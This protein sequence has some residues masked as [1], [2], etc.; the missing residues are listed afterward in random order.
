MKEIKKINNMFYT[1][2]IEENFPMEMLNI[3]CDAETIIDELHSFAE[4]I[5]EQKDAWETNGLTNIFATLLVKRNILECVLSGS[6]EWTK[7]QI[8]EYEKAV[9]SEKEDIE[10]LKELMTK[11]PQKS[12]KLFSEMMQSKLDIKEDV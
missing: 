2:T 6:K 11:Y 3:K 5:K 10:R 8:A 7:E 1:D 12:F 4:R 9:N